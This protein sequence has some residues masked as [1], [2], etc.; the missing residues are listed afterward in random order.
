MDAPLAREGMQVVSVLL[1]VPCY[2][3]LITVPCFKS[4]FGIVDACNRE[5]IEIDLL[6]THGESAITRG[7]SNMAALFLGTKHD[8][9]AFLDADIAID[10]D[11]FVRLLKLKK[12]IRGAAVNL[13]TLDHTECLSVF[14]DGQRLTRDLMG[15]VP[16]EVDY[17]GGSVMLI[18]REVVE[19]LSRL[20]SYL[21]YFDPIAG[22]GVHLFEEIVAEHTLWS[23]DYAFCR[24]AREKN[25][26]VWCDPRVRVTHYEGR[27]GWRF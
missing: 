4:V 8:T 23:E 19:T 14:K 27:V 10:G 18:E 7:R 20:Y 6:V 1:A 5:R 25:F 9:L 16:F 13:K 2:A 12:P 24:R 26:S 11:D 3:G 21:R 22:E 15:E 17:I